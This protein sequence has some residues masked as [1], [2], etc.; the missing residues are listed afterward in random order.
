MNNKTQIGYNHVFSH[1]NENINDYQKLT[2]ESLQWD[3][4]TTDF[5]KSLINALGKK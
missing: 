4:F 3:T 2:K 1:L 5:E